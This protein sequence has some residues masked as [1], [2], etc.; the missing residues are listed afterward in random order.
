MCTPNTELQFCTC[1]EGN[2]N[3]IKDIYIWTLYK[4]LGSRESS[5]RGKILMPT[6]NF[7][8]GIS[9]EN[10]SSKLNEGNIFDFEYTPQERDTLH[11]K[12]NA[13]N[14]AEYKYFSVIFRDGIW[15]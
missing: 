14:R 1:T 13:K 9:T 7:E 10:I 6:Y 5:L 3:D 8:N 2:I 12:F 11:I 4:Y 15:M